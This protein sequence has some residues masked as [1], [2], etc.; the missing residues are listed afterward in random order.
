MQTPVANWKQTFQ[1]VS[2]YFDLLDSEVLHYGPGVKWGSLNKQGLGTQYTVIR[3]EVD[4]GHSPQ[5]LQELVNAFPRFRL[6]PLAAQDITNGVSIN[7]KIDS[8]HSLKL[9][10][11]QSLPFPRL[12]F[13]LTVSHS[14]AQYQAL[15]GKVEQ[16]WASESLFNGGVH[17]LYATR[18]VTCAYSATLP[19]G[20]VESE[21]RGLL[22]GNKWSQASLGKPLYD[23]VVKNSGK[24]L[25]SNTPKGI[26]NNC[27]NEVLQF[28]VEQILRNFFRPSDPIVVFDSGDR[29]DALEFIPSAT[30]A[31]ILSWTL[32]RSFNSTTEIIV[33]N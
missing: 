14:D 6:V 28:L 7:I 2:L 20:E 10:L 25:R 30:L 15:I 18:T 32:N 9:S 5:R 23:M 33:F 3:G 26:Q 4:F 21:L 31:P 13:N 22:I 17:F 24:W 11:I 19:R 1:E 29:I 27:D 8:P 16:A 12:S